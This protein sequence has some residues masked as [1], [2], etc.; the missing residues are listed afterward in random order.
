MTDLK[1]LKDLLEYDEHGVLVNQEFYI[2]LRQEAI[3]WIK[4][5]TVQWRKEG[6]YGQDNYDPCSLCFKHFFNITDE[7]LK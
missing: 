1:T 5:W 7:E 6:N 4:A 2:K 3:K